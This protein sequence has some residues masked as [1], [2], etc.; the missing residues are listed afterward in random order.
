MP[1]PLCDAIP[2]PDA[3]RVCVTLAVGTHDYDWHPRDVTVRTPHPGET[4]D[5]WIAKVIAAWK[6]RHAAEVPDLAFVAVYAYSD[7]DDPDDE[8]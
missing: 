4:H 7:A 6:D 1:T 2:D 3:A 8:D 5:E